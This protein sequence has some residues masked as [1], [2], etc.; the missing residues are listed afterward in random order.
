MTDDPVAVLEA[1]ER[2][3]LYLAALA[4]LWAGSPAL[5]ANFPAFALTE[6]LH[7]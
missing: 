6:L 3:C 1:Q 5:P 4:A 2:L 7:A